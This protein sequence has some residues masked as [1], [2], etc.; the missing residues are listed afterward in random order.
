MP[1][2]RTN[3]D[4]PFFFEMFTLGLASK[5]AHCFLRSGA[6]GGCGSTWDAQVSEGWSAAPASYSREGQEGLGSR[7]VRHALGHRRP[8]SGQAHLGHLA[9]LAHLG[10]DRS[11]GLLTRG[12]RVVGRMV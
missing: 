5:L 2:S 12:G 6:L 3:T 8:L 1:H 9:G 11:V 4:F 10:K 7:R